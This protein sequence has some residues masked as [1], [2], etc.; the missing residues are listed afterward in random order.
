MSLT[1]A[2]R[3][4]EFRRQLWLE[5]SLP[6]L[7]GMP[8][9]LGLVFLAVAMAGERALATA[10]QT[11]FV[12]LV[13]AYGSRLA[14]A[15]LLDEVNEATWDAQ[16]LSSLTPWQLTWGKLLGGTAYAW[17][18]GLVCLGVWWGASLAAGEGLP[19]VASI[20]AVAGGVG[21]QATSL[22]LS[23]AAARRGGNVARRGGAWWVVMLLALPGLGGLPFQGSERVLVWWGQPVPT[24]PFYTAMAVVFAAW[25]VLGAHRLMAAALQVPQRP[26]A[27]VAFQ[28]WVALFAAGFDAP[29]SALGRF[30]FVLTVVA[31]ITAYATLFLEPPRLGLWQRLAARWREGGFSLATQQQVPLLGASVALLLVSGLLASLLLPWTTASSGLGAFAAAGLPLTLALLT[32]RDLAL[33]CAVFWAPGIKR[34]EGAAL[35]LLAL[36]NFVLPW[37]LLSLGAATL[38]SWLQPMIGSVGARSSLSDAWLSASI[39]ALQ[40]GIAYA[41]AR[42]Q[43]RPP[44]VTDGAAPRAH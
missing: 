9:V 43:W 28:V 31:S 3:N 7:I 38:A 32:L 29:G 27:W 1:L 40:A 11:G 30:A 12:I 23:L 37:L 8:A 5:F 14:S 4:P 33:A 41:I 24:F 26:V 25:A 18:G 39:A 35:V 36:I 44:A 10:G 16:R 42:G 22:I 17:Y 34:P 20:G 13:W 21:L 15:A 19:V 2:E 6:R